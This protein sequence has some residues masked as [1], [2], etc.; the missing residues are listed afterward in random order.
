M[1][2]VKKISLIIVIALLILCTNLN[3]CYGAINCSVN[4][5]GS[6]EVNSRIRG[7]N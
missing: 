3:K 6:G 2:I 1:K 5:S 4:L 7:C